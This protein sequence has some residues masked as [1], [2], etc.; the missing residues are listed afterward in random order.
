MNPAMLTLTT[1]ALVQ[2]GCHA[3]DLTRARPV[4]ARWSS[5][6]QLGRE[7]SI[8]A[9]PRRA[10]APALL[11]AG[12][13]APSGSAS[14]SSSII[15]LSKNIVGSGVLALAAGIAAFSSA[16]IAIVPALVLMTALGLLSGYT[17]SLIARVGDEVGGSTYRDTWAKVFGEKFAIIPAMTITFKTFVGGLSYAIILGDAF[18]SIAKLA[19]A[20]VAMCAPNF[21]IYLLSAL[22]L[23]PLSLMRDLSSLAVGSVIGTSGT[24]YTAVFVWLRKL[25]KSYA[26]GGQFFG[27]ISEAARPAFAA[28]TAASP[29]LNPALFVLVSMLSTTFLAHYNAPKCDPARL[30]PASRAHPRPYP[31]PDPDPSPLAPHA[32]ARP[33]TSTS[34][35]R[36]PTAAASSRPSTRCARAPSARPSSSAA[37]SWP[38]ASSPSAAPPRGSS[39][40]RALTLTPTLTLTLTP[41][42]PSSTRA[43]AASRT[44]PPCLARRALHVQARVH[45]YTRTCA[46]VG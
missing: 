45:M 13:P 41:R 14:V 31:D 33:G 6:P 24:L 28:P 27:A 37:P 46:R 25:D 19:G 26:P 34:S 8:A 18:A 42:G 23:L 5:Q 17:F 3:L 10:S 32:H 29:L 44:A 7:P 22:V 21:W 9:G 39:S 30:L 35:R 1:L 43:R 40:T 15:N 38:A 36:P 16:K 20:P 4:T 2:P 11:A 12:A